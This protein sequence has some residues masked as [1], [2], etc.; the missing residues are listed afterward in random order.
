MVLFMHQAMNLRTLT[1]IYL[2]LTWLLI[3]F[4]LSYWALEKR[5]L[6]YLWGMNKL[7]YF[8]LLF[9]LNLVLHLGVWCTVAFDA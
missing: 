6:V 2:F 5:V 7:A 3:G 8:S 4:W 9:C 1:L